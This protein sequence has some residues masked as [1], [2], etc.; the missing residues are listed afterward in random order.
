VLAIER[1]S[2]EAL[3]CYDRAVAANPANAAAY[4]NAAQLHTQ[5]F[6][7]Q[8]ASDALA[9]AS[10]LNF[11]LVR[12]YQ[13][14]ATTDGLL[15]LIDQWI[16]P[17]VFWHALRTARIP[18]EMAGSAPIGVRR[19]AESGGWPFSV[20]ALLFAAAGLAAGRWQHRSLHLRTCSNCGRIVCRRCSER[21][22][23][24][25]LCPRCAAIEAQAETADFGRVLLLRQRQARRRRHHLV[26]TALAATI[27]GYGLLAHRRVITPV[28]LLAALWLSVRVLAGTAPPLALDPRLTLPGQEVPPVLIVFALAIV[29]LVSLA[30]YFRLTEQERER[31]QALNQAQRGRL[32][33]ATRRAYD[34]AA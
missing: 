19:W 21:R 18:A 32:T 30:G 16:R 23:E 11:D 13:G 8:A 31:E 10:A 6:E 25:A 28:L 5:R 12:D 27:P 1:R 2:D 15:P 29:Y 26:H 9:R 34:T 20:L 7:Y 22:R 24:H 3:A 33:Q 4:F 17:Q 14:Q